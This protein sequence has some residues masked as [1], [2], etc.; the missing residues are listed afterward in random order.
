MDGAG[1]A[2]IK[3][4]DAEDEDNETVT[5]N[6]SPEPMLKPGQTFYRNPSIASV[7]FD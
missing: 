3:I 4:E 7:E 1:H 6:L 5:V 2:E